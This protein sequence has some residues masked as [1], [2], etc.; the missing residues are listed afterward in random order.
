MSDPQILVI[1]KNIIKTITLIGWVL[2]ETDPEMKILV[3]YLGNDPRRHQQGSGGSEI[4]KVNNKMISCEQL[5]LLSIGECWQ[6]AE[7]SHFRVTPLRSRGAGAFTHQLLQSLVEDRPAQVS[8]PQHIWLVLFWV[9]QAE[10]GIQS[11]QAE[12]QTVTEKR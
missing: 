4:E 10:V 11:L 5:E 7:G 3:L 2:T 8:T 1:T 9:E 6:P 12:S